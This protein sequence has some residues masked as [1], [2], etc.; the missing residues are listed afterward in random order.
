MLSRSLT[1]DYIL[2]LMLGIGAPIRAS[3]GFVYGLEFLNK[4]K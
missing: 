1:G 3:V 4:D 2:I